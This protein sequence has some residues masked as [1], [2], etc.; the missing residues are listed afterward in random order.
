MANSQLA[1]DKQ[2]KGSI[3]LAVLLTLLCLP[4][5]ASESDHEIIFKMKRCTLAYAYGI[6]SD[7]KVINKAAIATALYMRDHGVTGYSEASAIGDKATKEILG[8]A[9]SS[10]KEREER[11]KAINES[12]FCKT[13]M[14]SVQSN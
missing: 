8:T 6:H 1:T 14:S 13:F 3:Y 2:V 9:D 10:S 5:H 7:M 11:T 12:E 4:L